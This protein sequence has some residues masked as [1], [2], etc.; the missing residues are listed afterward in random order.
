MF[1]IMRGI[2]YNMR[3]MTGA[4]KKLQVV[5]ELLIEQLVQS[6]CDVFEYDFSL[7][8]RKLKE[9]KDYNRYAIS[10]DE[11][12]VLL[13]KLDDLELKKWKKRWDSGE[14]KSEEAYIEFDWVEEAG[15]K[16]STKYLWIH[17]HEWAMERFGSSD[18]VGFFPKIFVHMRPKNIAEIKRKYG[19]EMLSVTLKLESVS[20]VVECDNNRYEVMRLHD[21]RRPHRI[22]S[23]AMNNLGRKIDRNELVKNKI[24]NSGKES[25]VRVFKDE[26]HPVKEALAP[27]IALD[28]D[29]ICINNK[30]ELLAEE[31]EIIAKVSK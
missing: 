28:T 9:T 24:I 11:Q 8:R 29:S 3:I 23:Y 30:V 10:P 31:L 2:Y 14:T 21:G 25:L 22:I 7:M 18:P 6:D 16:D 13:K 12:Y 4:T 27:F 19:L 26:H 15:N 20:L 1:E 5:V 17:R